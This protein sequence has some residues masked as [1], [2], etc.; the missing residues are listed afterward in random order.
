MI[1]TLL[2][3]EATR[4]NIAD[5]NDN[6]PEF[7]CEQPFESATFDTD[8]DVQISTDSGRC[9]MRYPLHCSWPLPPVGAVQLQLP[10]SEE[11][12]VA[13]Y[14]TPTIALPRFEIGT[15]IETTS[16]LEALRYTTPD[17]IREFATLPATGEIVVVQTDKKRLVI[18]LQLIGKLD[19]RYH[20]IVEVEIASDDLENRVENRVENTPSETET[21]ISAYYYL[22]VPQCVAITFDES[23][24]CEG[25]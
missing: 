25:E 9:T 17:V 13:F 22:Y 19:P 12:T 14:E 20:Q 15:S 7:V 10:N 24:E 11:N 1:H 4:T 3:W 2:F 23:V 18:E 16:E 5:E 6:E 8:G 21:G